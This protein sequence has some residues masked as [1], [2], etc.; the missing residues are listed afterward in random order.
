MR[1]SNRKITFGLFMIATAAI[2][3]VVVER[4][5]NASPIRIPSSQNIARPSDTPKW[6]VVYIKPC[7]QNVRSGAPL[8]S[9]GRMTDCET[10]YGFIGTAYILFANGRSNPLLAP[11]TTSIEGGPSWIRSD[12]FSIT[13]KAEGTPTNAMMRGAMLQ[14]ILEDRFNLKVHRETRE[15][16]VY[17][18]SVA[19]GG[20]KLQPFREGSCIPTARDVLVPPP[21]TAPEKRCQRFGFGRGGRYKIDAQGISV[22]EFSKLILS[23][24]LGRPVIDKTGIMG[25][26]D[27]HLEFA[28][29][30]LSGDPAAA[31]DAVL[32][33]VFTVLEQL[34]LK[35]DSSKGPV[36]QILVIDAVDRPTS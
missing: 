15:V 17:A 18:L 12:R 2:T 33:S 35:V 34:G 21:P 16:P 27:F 30:S 20:P 23:S 28:G 1:Y 6:E 26:F 9:P 25:L 31:S 13:A 32:P 24:S 5:A 8:F 14:A 29:A 4:L 3:G 10:V 36:E 19:R 7:P 11:G 22:E